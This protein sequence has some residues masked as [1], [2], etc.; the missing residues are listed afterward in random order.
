MSPADR[1][2]A[3]YD[4]KVDD[5]LSLKVKE[6]AIKVDKLLKNQLIQEKKKKRK[7]DIKKEQERSN[8]RETLLETKKS[9]KGMKGINFPSIPRMSFLDSIRNFITFTL[10]GIVVNKLF[11]YLPQFTNLTKKMIGIIGTVGGFFEGIAKGLLNGFATFIHEGYKLRDG[12]KE[13]IGK[14]FGDNAARQFDQL[15]KQ[16]NLFFDLSLLTGLLSLDIGMDLARMRDRDKKGTGKI[17]ASVSGIESRL[18]RRLTPQELKDLK[19]KP[20]STEARAIQRPGT[21]AQRESAKQQR[22]IQ[23]AELRAQPKKPNL[24]GPFAKFAGPF[25]KFLKVAIP[26]V[27]AA[28]G[29][30]DSKARFAA[31][32]NL[33][34]SI[35]AA[36][37]A[38]DAFVT[39]GAGLTLAGVTSVIG[40]P[41]AAITGTAATVAAGLSVALD[42]ILLVR[43]V[44]EVM[45]IKI[46]GFGGYTFAQGGQITRNGKPA[47]E[48]ISRTVKPITRKEISIKPEKSQPG[49]DVG[50][51]KE[52]QKLFPDPMSP[53]VLGQKSDP[54]A[55]NP[56]GSL[57]TT[58]KIL[59][60][61]PFLGGVMGSAVDLSM[62][63][64]PNKGVFKSFGGAIGNL[65]QDVADN[66]ISLSLGDV[67]R[68]ISAMANGGQVEST[69]LL[70]ENNIGYQ[71]G[72]LVAKAFEGMIDSRV[73]EIFQDIK[74]Q[75]KKSS[76]EDRGPSGQDMGPIEYGP[77]PLNMSQKQAFSTIYQLAKSNNA[78]MPELVAGMAM[79]ESGYLTS[80]LAREANN[81]FGQTGTGNRGSI[82][83]KGRN[84][85][86]YN[87]LNDAVRQHVE[88]WNNTSK[89]GKGAGT[90][91]SPVAGLRA[92]LPIYAPTSDGNNHQN[93]IRS[94]SSI[95]TTM[96]FDPQKKNAPADLSTTAL[97]QQRKP[98]VAGVI[99]GY[100]SQPGTG[101]KPKSPGNFNIVQYITGDPSQGA[102]YDLAGHGR[103]DNYHDHIAFT[104][105]ADKERAKAALR[106]AGIKIGSEYRPG[107]P[108]YH[109]KNLAIDIPGYQWGGS[110]AIG[111][112]EYSGSAQ[113][114]RV[115]GLKDGGMIGD[116]PSRNIT[117]IKSYASYDSESQVIMMIQPIHYY[118]NTSNRSVSFPGFVVNNNNS[119][120]NSTF[121]RQ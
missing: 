53:V 119:R 82:E 116:K 5:V 113:V 105:E 32:D 78:S 28:L 60:T 31:G 92:I 25:G 55:I 68:S 70:K 90:Y 67:T 24:T 118:T 58:S 45:G 83:Y 59:K 102:N 98:G 22:R 76:E 46:P 39:L 44:L 47:G 74:N 20:G 110:G 54:D 75:F 63:Q 117:P 4:K 34:G 77:L 88:K 69:N 2:S 48:Q 73:N 111:N 38:L 120:S 52:I 49:K 71:I 14:K 29:A 23:G 109:G 33:G 81:P 100:T 41:V 91:D 94:V 87:S 51:K 10:L 13:F 16:L 50:G 21:K 27:G 96:G 40:I 79:H 99:P 104:T 3:A 8:I 26:G 12:F 66:Q 7:K 6:K 35:A 106:A 115:L 62:G 86:A 65:I 37:A 17:G 19:L 108:G 57:K 114:R 15:E 121:F 97:I 61:I 30:I 107:D 18:G 89:Y 80:Y 9:I 101:Y 56:L 36:S 85:A 42:V 43:D 112:R 95:L 64:R 1:M 84:W 93:Y 72:S 103:R 11:K